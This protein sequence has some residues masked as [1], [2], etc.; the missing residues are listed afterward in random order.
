MDAFMLYGP[1]VPDG[2]GACYNP[3][4]DNIV[5][6][7]SS[8]HSWEGTSSEFFASTLDE[9]FMQMKELCLKF[10]HSKDSSDGSEVPVQNGG[11]VTKNGRSAPFESGPNLTVP[12]A[13]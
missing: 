3:H 12:Q 1:V 13:T 11:H 4:P 6:C 9:S 10:S 7:V 5:V 8:F 2:Y